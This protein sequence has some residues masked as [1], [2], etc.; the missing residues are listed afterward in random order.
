M[1]LPLQGHR[2]R[3]S[4]EG[5]FGRSPPTL[6]ST[7]SAPH[8][9]RSPPST[10]SPLMG[11]SP[12]QAP[13]PRLLLRADSDMA[14]LVASARASPEKRRVVPEPE[15][16]VVAPRCFCL[17]SSQPNHPVLYKVLQLIVERERRAG[18]HGKGSIGGGTRHH[19]GRHGLSSPMKRR[20]SCNTFTTTITAATDGTASPRLVDH[21]GCGPASSSCSS[22]SMMHQDRHAARRQF[23]RYVQSEVT[24]PLGSSCST[25]LSFPRYANAA[26]RIDFPL[27]S[28]A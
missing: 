21:T 2:Q 10:A 23:L 24:F 15:Q 13:P 20:H 27:V 4:N 12:P 25:T 11:R 19:R 1:C 9:A 5:L 22:P 18:P 7:A 14:D 6:S 26:T 8:F 16:V 17:I 3:G 28:E